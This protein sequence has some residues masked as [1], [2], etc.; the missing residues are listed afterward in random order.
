MPDL[1]NKEDELSAFK[2]LLRQY[3]N[4]HFQIE[5]GDK[6]IHTD[7]ELFKKVSD[8]FV[9][10]IEQECIR[11]RIDE[12]EACDGLILNVGPF[13]RNQISKRISRLQ[14]QLARNGGER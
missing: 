14:A 2:E 4:R 11:A 8:L 9:A 13:A 12:A 1:H 3:N 6:K 5:P 10:H 7:G